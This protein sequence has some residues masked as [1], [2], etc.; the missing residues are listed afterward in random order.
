MI[1]VL[2]EER[3]FCLGFFCNKT[4]TFAFSSNL[5]CLGLGLLFY[6]SVTNADSYI[7]KCRYVPGYVCLCV[8]MREKGECT[9]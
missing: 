7:D 1:V 5:G 8:C 9:L 4:D 2:L 6:L 3:N